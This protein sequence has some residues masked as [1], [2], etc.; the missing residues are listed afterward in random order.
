MKLLVSLKYVQ[1]WKQA[2]FHQIL[3][4][5]NAPHDKNVC[6]EALGLQLLGLE[7]LCLEVPGPEVLALKV[8]GLEELSLRSAWSRSAC[9]INCNKYR[10]ARTRCGKNIVFLGR[11]SDHQPYRD[12]E[13]VVILQ[14]AYRL[15]AKRFFTIWAPLF[16]GPFSRTYTSTH[17]YRHIHIHHIYMY[18]YIWRLMLETEC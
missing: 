4:E 17:A 9:S 3:L 15:L 13:D 6:I 1:T 8:L 5:T 12:R 16:Q 10:A 11:A 18:I 7:L 14:I 2:W